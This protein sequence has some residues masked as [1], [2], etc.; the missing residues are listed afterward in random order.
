MTAV[1][2]VEVERLGGLAI[3]MVVI[4]YLV[5]VVSVDGCMDDVVL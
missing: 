4:G 3:I 5:L 1:V 2:T